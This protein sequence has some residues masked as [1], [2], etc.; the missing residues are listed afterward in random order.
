METLFKTSV[1][2]AVLL[3]R[4]QVI[5]NTLGTPVCTLSPRPFRLLIG[6]RVCV[7]VCVCVC[8]MTGASLLPIKWLLLLLLLIDFGQ[9]ASLIMMKH[10]LTEGGWIDV[11]ASF[12]FHWEHLAC[13]D[14]ERRSSSSSG[15][16]L[17]YRLSQSVGFH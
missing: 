11:A 10:R 16:C 17:F 7:C 3:Q 13:R 1:R 6:T 12:R 9:P 5:S 4:M 15:L 14:S 8:P 2:V